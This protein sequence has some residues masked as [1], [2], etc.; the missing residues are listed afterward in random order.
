MA[1]SKNQIKPKVEKGEASTVEPQS[2]EVAEQLKSDFMD[3]FLF[4]AANYIYVRKKLFISLAV[5]FIVILL[6]GYGIFRF[7][8]YKDNLRNEEIFKI[9]KIV[10]DSSLTE[11]QR[12]N[13]VVPLL[14]SFVREYNGTSQSTIAL[15]YRSSLHF[16]KN[17]FQD[18]ENDLKKVLSTVESNSGLFVLA[19]LHLANVLRDQ[20]KVDQAIEVLQAAKTENMTDIILMELA[21][22]Y[23]ETNQKE[24]AKQTLEN[25][26]QDYPNSS[27]ANKAKQMLERL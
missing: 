16:K 2:G 6:S 25:F 1:T 24:K 13:S 26:L 19:S 7:I 21:E 9:E 4:H 3:D 11:D 18:A 14:D 23:L 15:F 8:Q 12:Y 22:I 20:Q 17:Q 5:I 27:Y 10:N